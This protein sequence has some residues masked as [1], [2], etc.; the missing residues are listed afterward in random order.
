MRSSLPPIGPALAQMLIV[1]LIA[2]AGTDVRLAIGS[3]VIEG[4]VRSSQDEPVAGALVSIEG[5]RTPFGSPVLASQI[6]TDAEGHFSVALTSEDVVDGEVLLA[7]NIAP[8]PSSGLAVADTTNIALH[9]SPV[10]PPSDTTRVTVRLPY[11][12]D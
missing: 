2:C 11:L 9:L 7:L 5:R 1:G 8:A 10:T 4:E 6:T 12:P 3:G